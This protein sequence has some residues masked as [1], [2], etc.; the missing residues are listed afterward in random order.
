MIALVES[1][2]SAIWKFR[3]GR[4]QRVSTSSAAKI[5][6]FRE[7]AVVFAAS[8]PLRLEGGC[9]NRSA[10]SPSSSES[11]IPPSSAASS[12]PRRISEQGTEISGASSSV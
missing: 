10:A 5:S 7:D 6:G 12:I 2:P 3:L 4:V 8:A 1:T 9:P 11:Y